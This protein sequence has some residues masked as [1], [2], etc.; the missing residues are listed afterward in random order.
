MA[1]DDASRREARRKYVIE[2]QPLSMVA[3]MVKVPEST[4]RRWKRAAKDAG[5]DWDT[6][7]AAAMVSGDGL[8]AA[9]SKLIED[10]VVQHQ[11]AI[12]CLN[13]EKDLSAAGKA[14]VLASLA[15]SFN[16]TINSAGRV[17]P[18]ISQLGVAMDVLRRLGDFIAANH[19]HE[20]DTF[21]AVLEPFGETLPEA[22]K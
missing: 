3:L 15:D 4:L 17:S 18:Q 12:D 2:R 7:R 9:M 21:L 8:D 6:A 13:E 14:K 11:S 10:Y 20:V 5:D 22:Y 19:P 1:H 16:K